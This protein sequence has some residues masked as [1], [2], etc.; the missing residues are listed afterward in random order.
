MS[1]LYNSFYKINLTSFENDNNPNIDD[2][3]RK[4]NEQYYIFDSMEENIEFPENL[5]VTKYHGR[6]YRNM[7]LI[8]QIIYELEKDKNILLNHTGIL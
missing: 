8:Y 4:L 2:N 3:L 6:E 7:K 1:F 5:Y